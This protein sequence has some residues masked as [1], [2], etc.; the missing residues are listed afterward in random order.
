M[1]KEWNG[2]EDLIRAAAGR[3]KLRDKKA[4]KET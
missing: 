1:V 3:T 4:G 2:E